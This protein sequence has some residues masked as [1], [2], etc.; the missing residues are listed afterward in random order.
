[1]APDRADSDDFARYAESIDRQI[2]RV[3]EHLI[4]EAKNLRLKASLHYGDY[5]S[6]LMHFEAQ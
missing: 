6:K 1:L 3:N 4:K 2:G 5:R